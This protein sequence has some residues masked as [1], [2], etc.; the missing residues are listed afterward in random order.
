METRGGAS[1]ESQESHKKRASLEALNTLLTHAGIDTENLYT[2][3]E[4]IQEAKKEAETNSPRGNKFFKEKLHVYPDEE[5]FIYKRGDSK[6][7]IYYLRIYDDKGKKPIIKSLKTSDK[8]KALVKARMMF[9]EIKGKITRGERLKQITTGEL[10][11][12]YDKYLS[13]MITAIPRQGITPDN[14]RLKKYFLKNWSDYIYENGLESAKIDKISP[15]KARNFGYWML[16]KPKTDG[17]PRSR[18]LINN[19][20]S[21]IMRMYKEVAVRERYIGKENLP[22]IDRLRIQPDEGY[23]RDILSENQYERYRN[24]LERQYEKEKG[25]SHDEMLK[26]KIF[27]GFIEIL[28]NLG[29]RPKELL[30]LKISEISSSEIPDKRKN[31]NNL[32]ILIRKENSKTGKSRKPVAP[33]RKYVE[34]ILNSY[35]NLGITHEPN[36]FLFMNPRSKSRNAYCR[37]SMY[38]RL[39]RSLEMSGLQEDLDKEGKSITLYSGRHSYACWRLRHGDVP[40]H[41]LAKQMGTSIQKIENTYGHIELEQQSDIITKGQDHIK[42]TAISFIAL[43]NIGVEFQEDET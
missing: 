41:L 23:K 22:E 19:N 17:S 1:Q 30:G 9:M 24:F 5:A 40:I 27:R 28:Y 29:A 20:I 38:Q 15:D 36:D 31:E 42:R 14:Y 13:K 3:I 18:E 21:E 16:S 39:K 26:R 25:I 43:A 32:V 4:A 12:E 7:G 33:I 35:K 37:Q 6:T 2:A 34:R 11:R 8:A 10:I